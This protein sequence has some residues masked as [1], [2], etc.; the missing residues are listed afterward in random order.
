MGCMPINL[1][2]LEKELT[3]DGRAIYLTINSLKREDAF[4]TGYD[5]A[6][7]WHTLLSN[8]TP[9]MAEN[10][11]IRLDNF[12]WYVAFHNEGDHHYVHMIVFSDNPNEG[13]LRKYEIMNSTNLFRMA[14]EYDIIYKMLLMI[15]GVS[16]EN[17]I[18]N[19][20]EKASKNQT[21]K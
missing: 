8:L 11:K 2:K 17:G 19:I 6:E 16:F 18:K 10:F 4:M 5:N 1:S 7:S 9:T 21:V 3:T 12:R 13:Y 14:V 15:F 20:S